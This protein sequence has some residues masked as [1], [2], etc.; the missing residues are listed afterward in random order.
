MGSG[1]PQ[2]QNLYTFSSC[3]TLSHPAL[4]KAISLAVSVAEFVLLDSFTPLRGGFGA[5]L[6]TNPPSFPSLCPARVCSA[7]ATSAPAPAPSS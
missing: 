4:F 1:V 2:K 6:L 7:A 3:V 5:L